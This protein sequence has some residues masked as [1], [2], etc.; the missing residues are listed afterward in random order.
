MQKALFFAIV[1]LGLGGR[2]GFADIASVSGTASVA[3]AD[4][5]GVDLEVNPDGS[6]TYL[7]LN[8]FTG[9]WLIPSGG[10]FPQLNNTGVII[11]SLPPGSTINSAT[12]TIDSSGGGAVF[13]VGSAFGFDTTVTG[14]GSSSIPVT[15]LSDQ[16]NG[17]SFGSPITGFNQN[18][19]PLGAPALSFSFM[20]CS[21]GETL[22]VP[23]FYGDDDLLLQ[24]TVPSDPGYYSSDYNVSV[25][26]DYTISVDY[27]VAPEPRTYALLVGLGLVAILVSKK[28]TGDRGSV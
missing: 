9:M 15:S 17:C 26:V 27:T 25:S 8:Q 18:F 11:P 5:A 21:T 22:Y 16:T 13:N 23:T 1:I 4:G 7:A 10:G 14:D 24:W 28:R 20:P 6:V 19:W 3:E 12:F 2:S